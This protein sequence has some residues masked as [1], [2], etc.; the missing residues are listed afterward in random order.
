MICDCGTPIHPS[1][2]VLGYL[3]CLTCGELAARRKKHTVIPLH[4]Q[5]YM[6]F[7]GADAL[8]VIKQINPKQYNR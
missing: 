2:Y 1:R 7:S 6:A 3:T 4:K 5:G 8:A